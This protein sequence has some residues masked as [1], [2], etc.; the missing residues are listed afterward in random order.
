MRRRAGH[1]RFH[2]R[3]LEE[4]ESDAANH[5]APDD[6]GNTGTRGKGREQQHS[7][8][9]Q[10]E[11]HAAK[12]AGGKAVGQPAADRRHNRHHQR[13]WGHE[14]AGFDLRAQKNVLEVEGQRD[15]GE[16]LNRKGANG[17]RRRQRKQRPPD[18]IDRQHRRWMI[19][20]SAREH[21][22]EQK[23]RY[24]FDQDQGRPG[25]MR[26]T[27]DPDNEQ[28]ETGC[29]QHG[30]GKVES[31]G[32]P[33]CLRQRLQA[34]QDGNQAEGNIDCKQPWPRSHRQNAGRNRRP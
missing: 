2:V 22:A 10:H 6:I 17:G 12:E 30:A 3:R 11:A 9:E 4:A 29:G 15:E 24:N 8:G 23:R 32:A 28:A 19:G 1:D 31:V 25:L 5:H 33:G 34:D 7:G 27:A 13:P 18:Q 21:K 16:T 14:E 20:M 26:R